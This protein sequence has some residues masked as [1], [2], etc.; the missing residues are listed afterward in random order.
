MVVL[1]ENVC[2][3]LLCYDKVLIVKCF[4]MIRMVAFGNIARSFSSLP[5]VGC[6]FSKYNVFV[7]KVIPW[8]HHTAA[9]AAHRSYMQFLLSTL[10]GWSRQTR[11]MCVKIS[12]IMRRKGIC[13]QEL[14]NMKVMQIFISKHQQLRNSR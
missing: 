1:N 7:E 6:F 12:V 13:S 5:Y 11:S 3:S 8:W 10:H 9:N 2:C 14:S 4:R